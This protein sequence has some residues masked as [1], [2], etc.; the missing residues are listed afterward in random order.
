[1][2][3]FGRD[4]VYRGQRQEKAD[5]RAEQVGIA[6]GAEKNTAEAYARIIIAVI[7]GKEMQ[8]II[9]E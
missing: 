8:R 3:S 5:K 6:Y 4:I 1:M 7:A 2:L 9:S